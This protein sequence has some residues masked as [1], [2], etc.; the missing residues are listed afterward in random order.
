MKKIV[1]IAPKFF[2]IHDSIVNAFEAK[3]YQTYFYDERMNS[4]KLNK[5][6]LRKFPGLVQKKSSDITIKYLRK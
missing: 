6:I 3:G 2:G 4:T 5:I 1:V